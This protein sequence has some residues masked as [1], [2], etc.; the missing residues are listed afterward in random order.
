MYHL[1]WSDWLICFR[2]RARVSLTLN[3]DSPCKRRVY[4]FQALMP[5]REPIR[6]FLSNWYR[7]RIILTG[8]APP[9]LSR[10]PASN[11]PGIVDLS[12]YKAMSAELERTLHIGFSDGISDQ[13]RHFSTESHSSLVLS[14][15]VRKTDLVPHPEEW[16]K[17]YIL[18]S[19][20]A[21]NLRTL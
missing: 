1:L 20:S 21:S 11:L 3:S 4:L 9:L 17:F 6:G 13:V 19:T 5:A 2:Y 7:P 10:R 8:V 12:K 15:V 16:I 18:L 14:K